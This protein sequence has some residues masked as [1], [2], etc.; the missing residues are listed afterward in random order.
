MSK[1]DLYPGARV[2]KSPFYNAC[3]QRGM[4]AYSVYN[5]TYMPLF[6]E[7]PAKD[8][9]TLVNAVSLWDVTCER[10][11][12]I[13]G[14]DAAEFVQYLTPRRVVDCAIWQ[15]KYVFLCTEDGG[16]VNDPVLIRLGPQHFWLSLADSD[17]L[18]WARGLAATGTWRVTI[19]EPDVSPLQLQGPRATDVAVKVFGERLLK[20][21][22]YWGF[23]TKI[24]N[25]IP[26]VVTRTGWSN[27][28]GYEIYLRDGQY[29]TELFDLLMGYGEEYGIKPGAP[30]AIRRI[31]AGLL[32][33]G[34]DATLDNNPFQY[35][36]LRRICNLESV[37]DLRCLSAEGLQKIK[38]SGEMGSVFTGFTI[39]DEEG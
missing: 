27:E 33:Y 12:E 6:F 36:H 38:N 29:G 34:A 11:V 37:A 15:C 26:V 17:V 14:P 16:I 21:K 20:L 3:R 24:F 22:Y 23:E 1:M 8:Y 19:T 13:T 5:H 32:S 25:R 35:P 39:K 10:Q 18:L 9:D 31:E 4:N 30:N 7:S 2:R 28:R